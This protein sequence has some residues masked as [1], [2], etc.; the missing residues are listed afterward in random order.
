M[1]GYKPTFGGNVD[2]AYN[3]GAR[4]IT[5]HLEK[6][7]SAL[8]SGGGVMAQISSQASA[9][10]KGVR[11]L[12]VEL[13]VLEEKINKPNISVARFNQLDNA[14]R[15]VQKSL[16]K[17]KRSLANMPF[18]AL[19]KGLAKVT[20]GVIGF[21]AA[22]V[23]ISFDFVIESIKRVY[24]LQE[25]WTKAIGAFNMK[26]G[27]M[28]SGLKG[29]TKAAVSWSSTVRGLTDG[30]IQE[31]IQMFGE[32]TDAIGE[33]VQQGDDFQRFGLQLARGF[34]L[35]GA[36]AG[37]LTKVFSVI[38]DNSRDASETMKSLVKSAN[39][40]NIPT[41][42]LAKDLLDSSKYMARFGKEGQKTFVEGAA[43]VRKYKI[44]MDQL[45]G[46]VE[47]M[48]MFDEAAKTASR[49][50]AAFGTMVNSMD[51]MLEDDP[52]KRLDMIRQQMLAQGMT[53]D[54]LTPK[55]RRYFSETMKLSDDQTAALL[56]AKNAN[57]SYT[58]FV[59]KAEKKQKA[60]L[61]A[62]AM[63]EKQLRST[64][65]TMY[66]FG[67]AFDRV[68]V[69][70]AKA[71][72]PL[73][74]VLGL[75]KKGDKDFTSFGQ[76]MEG[77][78]KTVIHFF[79]SLAGNDKW[80][81]Y[82]RELGKDL[83][84]AGSALKDFVMSGRA[85]D[86]VGDMASGMKEFYTTVRDLALKA[87]PMLKP[88]LDVL[89]FLSHHVAALATAWG[90]LKAFNG[91]GGMGTVG[92]LV[93]K[94]GGM[95]NIFSKM[96]GAKG[97]GR[98]GFAGAAGA[99]GGAIGGT[100]AGIGSAIGAFGGSFLG[101]IGTIL[102][103][104]VGGF[105]GKGIEMLFGSSHT[106]TALEKA[107]D[108][109]ND[110]ITSETKRREGLQGVLDRATE[111]E[112][113]SDRLRN[114]KNK[115]LHGMESQALSQKKHT[116]VLGQAEVDMLKSRRDELALFG[117]SARDNRKLIDGLGV[118]SKL[119]AEQ[120]AKLIAGAEAF[121]DQLLRLR[122]NAKQQADIDMARLQVGRIGQEK[123]ALEATTKLRDV[124]LKSMRDQLAS[125]GGAVTRSNNKFTGVQGS[126]AD[127]LAAIRDP[128][129]DLNRRGVKISA[130]DLQRLELEAKIDKLDMDNVEAQK[131]LTKAQTDF[132]EQQVKINLRQ[133]IRGDAEFIKYQ[134]SHANQNLDDQ[135]M[136]FVN[137][138]QSV[139]GSDP[140]VRQLLN[141][142]INFGDVGSD[143]RAARGLNVRGLPLPANSVFNQASNY[144]GTG[145]AAGGAPIIN[146]TVNN[147]GGVGDFLDT[148]VGYAVQQ[149]GH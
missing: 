2:H 132:F 133:A 97:L 33:V 78:T 47:G 65:Q 80:M 56:S 18:N 100:G 67:A 112:E 94:A 5:G 113:A 12:T 4:D 125:Y 58:D 102:G 90:G 64:A 35:G 104:I 16:E 128:S 72:K 26:I 139:L 52:A 89:M 48:D 70:I 22:L 137:S 19:E 15:D 50:N 17:A 146:V 60:D 37:Q 119:T 83:Q 53:Y 92:T 71:I 44:T 107:H 13:D 117:K 9:A 108:E 88:L 76:V 116:L 63:M 138:G 51:Q 38:G 14:I 74:E 24:E 105:I 140:Y 124:Q 46:S 143:M 114:A 34:N 23:G 10:S 123:D 106:R 98:L 40:A 85:A 77:I 39:A 11:D 141:E 20:K 28:T 93:G 122:D 95:G 66:A 121:D 30:D 127:I 49:L 81:S 126:A 43:W 7:M 29:A 68:T 135:I 147:H 79:E 36:G 57:E 91:L 149:G 144:A 8:R 131:R 61:D 111:H 115:L 45:R 3:R 109:L 69:A 96:G 118:G 87:V 99:V 73:L 25:R 103:P 134:A 55:Q 129:S 86:F 84:R 32:F 42:L 136:G 101:P 1:A 59:A 31:G 145:V 62:K 148:T 54:K 120:I 41:N 110:L 130:K 6:S 21:N 142:G 82:M 27:G 75:A